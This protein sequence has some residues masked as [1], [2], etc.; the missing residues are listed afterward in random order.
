LADDRASEHRITRAGR[1]AGARGPAGAVRRAREPV[2][3]WLIPSLAY[4]GLLGGLGVTTKLALRHVSW[5]EVIIWTAI[6]YA[7]IA[8]G[9]LALGQGRVGIGPGTVA[10]VASGVLA[11]TALVVFYIALRSG[12]ASRVVPLTSA[13]P[14]V[15]LI[16]SALVLAERITVL[17]GAGAL[18]VVCGVV[19]LSLGH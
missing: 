13:Y 8:I 1:P 3:G 12:D 4:I 17:R 11:S 15:T 2:S 5:Q 7:V 9:M 19:L 16:L 6:V 10:A 14:V 18:I